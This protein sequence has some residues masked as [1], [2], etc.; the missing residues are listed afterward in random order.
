M[1]F[2]LTSTILALDVNS[3]LTSYTYDDRLQTDIVWI[4]DDSCE[5][6]LILIQA[7]WFRWYLIVVI[8]AYYVDSLKLISY[9]LYNLQQIY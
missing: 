8:V 4:M 7:V 6:A 9:L 2:K 5:L 1:F 3:E